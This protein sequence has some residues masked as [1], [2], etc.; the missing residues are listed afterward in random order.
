MKLE[1]DFT[2]ISTEFESLPEGDYNVV[3]DDI[4]EGESGDNKLP[5][6]VFMLEVTDGDYAGRKIRDYVTLKTN[7]G[8]RNDI[9]YGRV[10]AYAQAILGDDAGNGENIDT[11]DLKKGSCTIVVKEETYKDKKAGGEEKKASRIKKVL[12]M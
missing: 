11:D 3:V 5:Q 7:K 4:E 10:K 8:A 1:A 12:A 6:L 9:G 2:K